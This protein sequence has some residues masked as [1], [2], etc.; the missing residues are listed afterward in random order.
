MQ[1]DVAER[2]AESRASSSAS[3][4]SDR[5]LR[6]RLSCAVRQRSS[7]YARLRCCDEV[8]QSV[9]YG[10]DVPA[11]PREDLPKRVSAG[12]RGT[13]ELRKG[14]DGPHRGGDGTMAL[15]QTSANVFFS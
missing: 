6:K 14:L 9:L 2:V 8:P 1:S 3:S 12:R 10:V 4:S 15:Q 5:P 13:L 11:L 7:R